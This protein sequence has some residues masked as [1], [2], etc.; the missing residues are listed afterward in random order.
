LIFVA[1]VWTTIGVVVAFL[2]RRRGHDFFVWLVLGVGFGPLSV[3]LALDRVRSHGAVEHQSRGMPTPRHYGFDIVAGVDGSPESLDA[4]RSAIDLFGGR[5]SSVTLA[6][7]V[8]HEA[9]DSYTGRETQ[10]EARQLLD[11]VAKQVLYDPVDKI[12]LF[13]RPEQQLSEF[14]RTSGMEMIVVGSKGKGATKALLGSVSSALVGAVELP[15]F[16]GP[17]LSSQAT[18]AATG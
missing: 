17:A 8:S 10:T 1:L 3:P 9:R 14:A 15:V 16:V 11:E 7:V 4:I 6:T 13:G 18:S 2:M 12:V 5:I